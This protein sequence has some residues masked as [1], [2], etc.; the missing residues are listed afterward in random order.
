MGNRSEKRIL[1]LENQKLSKE[2]PSVLLHDLHH[3]KKCRHR[4]EMCNQLVP[5]GVAIAKS[6]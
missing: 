1:D 3:R 5:W 4:T 2:N 6:W